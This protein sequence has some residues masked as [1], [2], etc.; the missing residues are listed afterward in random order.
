MGGMITHYLRANFLQYVYLPEII[1][2][3]WHNYVDVL[4]EKWAI[5]ETHCCQH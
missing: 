4:S 3:G 2:I 5:F 1:K